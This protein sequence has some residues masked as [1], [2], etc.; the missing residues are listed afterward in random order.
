MMYDTQKKPWHGSHFFNSPL[1]R[2]QIHS[3]I[4][5]ES[6]YLLPL[7]GRLNHRSVT[8]HPHEHFSVSRIT[9][10]P[11][12]LLFLHPT[13]P[14]W[15]HNWLKIK[16]MFCRGHPVPRL[17]AHV[18]LANPICPLPPPALITLTVIISPVESYNAQH[19]AA[20]KEHHGPI[21]SYCWCHEAVCS[22]GRGGLDPQVGEWRSHIARDEDSWR[23]TLQ[24]KLEK[25]L[26]LR[27]FV[28]FF[29]LFKL[30]WSPQND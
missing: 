28:C 13:P 9:H 29:F 16:L 18:K 15:E 10:R 30:L 8:S 26:K 19:A 17:T 24:V 2:L 7:Y 3:V 20:S 1:H 27:L 11:S 12:F 23:K 21:A 5:N 14:S 25:E 4:E 6:P 22:K